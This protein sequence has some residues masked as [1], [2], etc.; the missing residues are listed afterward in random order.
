MQKLID[1]NNYKESL[2]A[3]PDIAGK[4]AAIELMGMMPTIDPESL[5][6]VR[7]LREELARVTAER[8]EYKELFFSYKHV[9]GGIE[10]Q[11][12]GELVEAD[13]TGRC[14]VLPDRKHTSEDG[15]NAL[16]SAMNTC[17]Y[18]NNPVTRYIADAVVEK[19][20][21]EAAQDALKGGADHDQP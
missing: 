20:A 11:R 13:K 5:P 4:R 14:V 19:L 7:Q 12:I 1:A 15:E 10:P 8:D 16:K 21:R 17:Y 9:C 3:L 6:I 18:H 2:K